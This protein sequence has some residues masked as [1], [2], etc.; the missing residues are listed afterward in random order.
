MDLAIVVAV[1]PVALAILA[2]GALAV[3]VTIGRPVL[4]VQPQNG[5][6]GKVFRI[7]KLRALQAS[8]ET[9]GVGTVKR[10]SRSTPVDLF[11]HRCRIDELPQLLNVLNG[12]MSIVGPRWE[13]TVLS[14]EYAR[15]LLVYV[16][17]QFDGPG[18]NGW[19]QV[20]GGYA[21]YF[22]EAR[23]KGWLRPVLCQE[24]VLRA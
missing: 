6:G 23:T 10:V 16:Y 13:W 21:P 11:L 5:L 18:I 2:T 4:F 19:S 20:R 7:C 22:D 3:L 24:P 12:D 17:R 8:A 15:H 1:L 14:A 9:N